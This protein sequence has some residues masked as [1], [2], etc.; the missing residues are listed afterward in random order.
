MSE[1]SVAGSSMTASAPSRP[2]ASNASRKSCS[3][4]TTGS[5]NHW[6]TSS[7]ATV[8]S[9]HIALPCACASSSTAASS[10]GCAPR[11]VQSGST[12]LLLP[13]DDLVEDAHPRALVQPRRAGRALRVHLEGDRA[14]AAAEEFREGGSQ[15]RL[16]DPAATP[17]RP[18]AEP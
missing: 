15:Q 8:S 2:S 11:I 4:S 6:C 12:K 3:L 1:W 13:D 18:H 14:L 10:S 17:R 7:A 16:A 5:V 9:R